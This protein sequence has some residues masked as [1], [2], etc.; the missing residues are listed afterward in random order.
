MKKFILTLILSISTLV[1]AGCPSLYPNGKPI[2]VPNTVE[3]CNSFYVSLFD[4]NN[5]G[6]VLVSE[7]LTKGTP[8]GSSSRLNTFRP[9]GRLGTAGPKLA[10]YT[11]S[12]YDR[13]HLAASDDGSTDAQMKDTFL[14]SNM[15]PQEPTL[16]QIAWVALESSVRQ[17]FLNSNTDFYILNVPVYTSPS[18]RIGSGIP[19]P[20][21]YWKIVYNGKTVNYYFAPNKPHGQVQKITNVDITN[22]I[23]T[24]PNF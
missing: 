17:Q 11:N 4:K 2:I 10:D 9:D 5:K 8:V 13:G 3:L 24:A 20:T 22:L 14:L 16:N 21:G 15:T 6:V 7:K 23:K 12:G 1:Y 18:K 19:V